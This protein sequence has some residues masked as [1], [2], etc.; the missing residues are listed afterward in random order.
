MP[1][2]AARATLNGE[3][4]SGRLVEHG[5]QFRT[6]KPIDLQNGG[7]IEVNYSF[8][9][10][11]RNVLYDLNYAKSLFNRSWDKCTGRL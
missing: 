3:E 4:V 10:H 1:M 8:S 9:D 7:I 5:D 2:V 11:S 6:D